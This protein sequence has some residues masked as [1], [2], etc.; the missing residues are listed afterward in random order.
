MNNKY[1]IE[2]MAD[3]RWFYRFIDTNSKGESLVIELSLCEDWK[4]SKNSLPKLW[5]KNGYINRV[6]ET[7]WH[8]STY[9]R[10]TEGNCYG[11]YNPQEKLSE[12][13]KRMVINFDWMF[14]AT[15]E[16]REKLINEVY[17]LFSTA[18]GKTATEEKKEKIKEFAIK[19]NI[20]I[21]KTIPEGWMEI[22]NVTAP[23]G[24][25]W[26]SNMESLKSR[27]RKKAILLAY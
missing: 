14:E 8:I 12:D 3:A 19:N 6:L 7:Y 20:D 17:S 1:T 21:Y 23:A 22:P 11:R 26:I 13:K 10:D 9:V 16:N 5:N 24:T 18:K 27:N 4:E 2:Q 15:E 25:I